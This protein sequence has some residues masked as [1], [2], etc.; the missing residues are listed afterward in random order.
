MGAVLVAA[1]GGVR[2]AV[3]GFRVSAQSP[4][5]LAVAAALTLAAWWVLARRADR[6][7]A[8]LDEAW[9]W[10]DRRGSTLILTAALGS[11]AAA[12]WFA[13]RS[14]SGAD[15]SGYL[16]QAMTFAS[17]RLTWPDPLAQVPGWPV[18]HDLTVPLGWRSGLVAGVQ[19]PTYPPGLPL[20]MALPHALGGSTF[21]CLVV[22]LAAGVAV[23]ATGQLAARTSGGAA[24]MSAA[25]LLATTPVYLFQSVQPMSD[26]P[27]TAAWMTCWMLLAPPRARPAWAGVACAVAVLIRP[28]LAPLAVVPLMFL[29]RSTPGPASRLSTLG[30]R[31]LLFALPVSLAALL[32]ACLQSYWYGSPIRS[33]YG[34]AGE[35]FSLSNVAVNLAR[36]ASWLVTTT[37]AL[38]VAPIGVAIAWWNRTTR[39]LTLFVAGVAAAYLVYAVFDDWSYLRFLLPALAPLSIFGGVAI[40]A[41]VSRLPGPARAAALVAASLVIVGAGVSEARARGA[42]LLQ[43]QHRRI[44]D[45]G[46]WLRTTVPPSGVIVS[47]EQSGSLRY[48]T[49]R[50]ILRWE[51]AAPD[52]L[53]QAL[54]ALERDGREVWIALDAWE[55][56]LVRQKFR[57]LTVGAL[58][59]PPAVEAGDTVRTRAWRLAD[60]ERFLRG[61]R[62]VTRRIY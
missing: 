30:S 35:L 16:S 25:L 28:N 17:G 46:R 4:G 62:I 22:A 29:V 32:L 19:V 47:G 34:T 61:Q 12:L 49:R 48:Y 40:A 1:G 60:R 53:T 9:A 11:V 31:F 50:S 6:V 42:F 21:A 44:V 7:A 33:G 26:V 15:A 59:W 38:L 14:A 41:A 37:P 56:P 57:G 58:D 5:P 18:G 10:I 52:E 2:V 36:Y 45:V 27:A 3:G 39:W 23:W 20:L 8:D 51:A 43:A 13:T 55:E 24:G 54:A